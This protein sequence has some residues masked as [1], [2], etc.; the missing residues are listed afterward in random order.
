MELHFSP[1][2]EW[3]FTQEGVPGLIIKHQWLQK[4]GDLIEKL[5]KTRWKIPVRLT[6]GS[7]YETSVWLPA[8]TSRLT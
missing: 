1:A 7:Q 2:I 8:E 3:N 4:P 6:T 5:F